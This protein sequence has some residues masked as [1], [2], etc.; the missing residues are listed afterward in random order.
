MTR[1]PI[2]EVPAGY[3][4]HRVGETWLVL[5]RDAASELIQLRLA[6][7]AVRRTLFA[8]APR[9]GRGGAPSV[10]LGLR[11]VVLRRYRHGGLFGW[12]TGALYLGPQRALS[13]LRTTASAEASGAPVPHVLCLAL[14]PVAGPLWSALIGTLEQPDAR[15]LLEV[16][17]ATEEPG[18]RRAL[19][20]A[21]GT[22]LGRLHGAGLEHRDL[23]V[24]NVLVAGPEQRIVVVDLDKAT[25][26]VPGPV[27]TRRRA[28]NLGRL[29]RS[30]VKNG[31]WGS[32]VGRR[33]VA[34]FV[35]GYTRG[36]RPLRRTLRGWLRR[37]RLKLALHRFRYRFSRF[38]RP[39][40]AAAPPRPT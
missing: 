35:S 12:L 14:W 18:D 23:Q 17:A 36:Q 37:E 33:E 7:P 38:P 4:I 29:T 34:A 15:D 11:S 21:V 30:I 20:R 40:P 9:R 1:D 32:Q 5:D 24:R 25:F 26:H 2:G 39:E 3:V 16:L 31:L 27:P 13:E 6:D 28:Q 19:A 22:A 10:P 8:R